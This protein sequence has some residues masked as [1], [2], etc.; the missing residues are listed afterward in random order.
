MRLLKVY[1]RYVRKIDVVVFFFVYGD[2]N[3]GES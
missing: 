3:N 1:V 2:G